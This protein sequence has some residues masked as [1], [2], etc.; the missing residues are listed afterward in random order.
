MK[1]TSG[2]FYAK[3]LLFGEYSILCDSMGLTIPYTHFKGEL[4]FIK[5]DK[6][7]DYD[8]A[9]SSNKLLREYSVY[10]RGLKDSGTLL[11]NFNID[12]FEHDINHSL[13][14]ESSIPQGYGVGSSGALVA[15][16]YEKYV[17][18]HVS[19]AKRLT[20]PEILELKD[21]FSQLESYFHGTSSGMDPLNCYV[22]HP[23]L[24]HNKRD[25]CMVGIPRNKHDKKGAIFLINTGS[26]GK[27]GPLVNLFLDK[28]KIDDFMTRVREEMIPLND[29]CIKSLI[30]GETLKFFSTLKQL[31]GFLY[32]NLAPMIPETFK[33]IW[34]YGL[35]TQSFYLKLC[36]SGGGGFLLGFTDDFD[37]AKKEL[38]DLDVD[39][40]PVYKSFNEAE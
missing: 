12:A 14:F 3:I 17:E 39:I 10:I 25:I 37:K 32:D 5:D 34:R 1:H 2:T 30:K 9:V 27:T 22:K 24:I 11:C 38:H 19:G 7:T 18:G 8:F 29:A 40:I 21:V 31:S 36:G 26:P 33:K 6:Y 16:L 13:Y 23:L 35:E 4:S 20:K 28:C 15:A